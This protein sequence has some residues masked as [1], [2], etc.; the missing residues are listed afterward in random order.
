MANYCARFLAQVDVTEEEWGPLT[1]ARKRETIPEEEETQDELTAEE[2][3]ARKE[4][5]TE[6]IKQ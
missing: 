5:R 6:K 2:K 4:A 1:P 3:E